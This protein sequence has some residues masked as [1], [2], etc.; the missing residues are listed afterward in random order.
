VQS[1]SGSLFEFV[2]YEHVGTGFEGGGGQCLI[3]GNF[4][5][6]RARLME[7]QKAESRQRITKNLRD[8]IPLHEFMGLPELGPSLLSTLS[9]LHPICILSARPEEFLVAFPAMLLARF[10]TG[11]IRATA[12]TWHVPDR[13]FHPNRRRRS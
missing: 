8:I 4:E 1:I 12:R 13:T 11:C 10:T 2:K 5:A 3:G 7:K 6:L 9:Y